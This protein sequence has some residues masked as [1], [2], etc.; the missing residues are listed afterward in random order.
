MKLAKNLALK[1]ARMSKMLT[2][3]ELAQKVNQKEIA[4]T[5]IETGRALPTYGLAL[6]IAEVLE[7]DARLL[8]PDIVGEIN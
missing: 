3:N 7:S 1:Q 5:K 2:Q 8:F 4:I 6:R